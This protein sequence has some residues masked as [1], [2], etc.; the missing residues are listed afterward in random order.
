MDEEIATPSR[1]GI[2]Q[3]YIIIQTLV[4]FLSARRALA[5]PLL[6][7]AFGLAPSKAPSSQGLFRTSLADAGRLRTMVAAQPSPPPDPFLVGAPASGLASH[8][9]PQADLKYYLHSLCF[10]HG[11]SA[12]QECGVCAFC[13]VAARTGQQGLSALLGERGCQKSHLPKKRSHHPF[14]GVPVHMY[15]TC[16]HSCTSVVQQPFHLLIGCT[17][18]THTHTHPGC[19]PIMYSMC[20]CVLETSG[21]HGIV[22]SSLPGLHVHPE[23]HNRS[24]APGRPEDVDMRTQALS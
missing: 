1:G 10:R 16:Y 3:V 8:G 13:C 12:I 6:A 15:G 4:S 7:V 5:P 9:Q 17:P 14:P 24:L 23:Q 2:E 11:A 22:E 21:I 20:A 19:M 18:L